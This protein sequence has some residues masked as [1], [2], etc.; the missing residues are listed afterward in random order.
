MYLFLQKRWRAIRFAR[1]APGTGDLRHFPGPQETRQKQ[2]R[3]RYSYA[4]RNSMM[5]WWKRKI[6]YPH[7]R[8]FWD[9]SKGDRTRRGARMDSPGGWERPRA[10]CVRA[11]CKGLRWPWPIRARASKEA[12]HDSVACPN[13][14]ATA[15]HVGGQKRSWS[16]RAACQAAGQTAGQTMLPG[17]RARRCVAKSLTNSFNR[18]I[19]RRFFCIS[20]ADLR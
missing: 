17:H 18:L 7:K 2:C 10:C 3:A 13:A 6:W 19:H 14:R 9:A 15:I 11:W 16:I 20:V 8:H 5:A 4:I 12:R 1:T